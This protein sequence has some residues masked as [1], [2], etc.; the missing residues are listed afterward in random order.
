MVCPGISLS[1]TWHIFKKPH[2]YTA[3]TG[4][5]PRHIQRH[6]WPIFKFPMVTLDMCLPT[7]YI[8]HAGHLN[9]IFFPRGKNNVLICT[10]ILIV[11]LLW[12]TSSFFF[13]R[14]LFI[15][16]TESTSRRSGRQ[17]ERGRSS[18]PAEQ[19]AQC[20]AHSQDPGIM[21]WAEGRRLTEPPRPP[22]SSYIY[23]ICRWQISVN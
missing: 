15:Y 11:Q 22:V 9:Q 4:C 5:L 1:A 13:L 19:G 14:F 10:N 2:R 12:L 8:S 7:T 21:A 16:L 17:R 23:G 20:W 18:L 3:W 6:V